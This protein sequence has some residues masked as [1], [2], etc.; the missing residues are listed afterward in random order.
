MRTTVVSNCSCA[1]YLSRTRPVC[2]GIRQQSLTPTFSDTHT[3]YW[4]KREHTH[5]HIYLLGEE[6]TSRLY[7]IKAIM[8]HFGNKRLKGEF[9]QITKTYV[10]TCCLSWKDFELSASE[11]S[12]ATPITQQQYCFLYVPFFLFFLPESSLIESYKQKS[13]KPASRNLNI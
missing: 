5:T 7:K 9:T 1:P 12:A 10:L 11:M 8:L 13:Q 4:P 3:P 6:I 2:E